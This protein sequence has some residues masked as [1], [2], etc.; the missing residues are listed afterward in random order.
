M[1]IIFFSFS[2]NFFSKFSIQNWKRS[3]NNFV[4]HE[5][6]TTSDPDQVLS[7][8]ISINETVARH[9][10]RNTTYPCFVPGIR[11]RMRRDKCRGARLIGRT[12]RKSNF[13]RLG[14]G[15]GGTC[16][17]CA[18]ASV[19]TRRTVAL[20]YFRRTWY[21]SRWRS[22]PFNVYVRPCLEITIATS[23]DRDQ[24]VLMT[25]RQAIRVTRLIASP[26]ENTAPALFLIGSR[27]RSSHDFVSDLIHCLLLPYFSL[28][29]LLHRTSCMHFDIPIERARKC[30]LSLHTCFSLYPVQPSIIIT[31]C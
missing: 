2:R 21:K 18:R 8:P 12:S 23:L 19:R 17:W 13:E 22:C 20:G 3:I 28:I 24:P 30:A 7:D 31:I 5:K 27:S 10:G 6:L 14:E 4:A 11:A 29:F 26:R 15:V 1:S 25:F 9:I 16:Q